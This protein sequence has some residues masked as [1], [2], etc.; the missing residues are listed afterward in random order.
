M[1]RDDAG[2]MFSEED[3]NAIV[4]D[5]NVLSSLM[6][7][8]VSFDVGSANT[9]FGPMLTV[10]A[11]VPGVG[12]AKFLLTVDAWAHIGRHRDAAVR[13]SMIAANL[14]DQ[15]VHQAHREW[16]GDAPARAEDEDDEDDDE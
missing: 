1:P 6:S 15:I 10:S 2:Q 7:S 16:V 3:V 12:H 13:G 8:P 4:S 9:L 5:L 11:S 14:L